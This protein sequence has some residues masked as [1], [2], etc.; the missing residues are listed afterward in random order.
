MSIS[1][2]GVDAEKR[3]PAKTNTKE[4]SVSKYLA[5]NRSPS[6]E[7]Y[8]VVKSLKLSA[9]CDRALLERFTIEIISEKEKLLI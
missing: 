1:C 6:C 3:N 8:R 7:Q 9:L 2:L 5:C 4:K